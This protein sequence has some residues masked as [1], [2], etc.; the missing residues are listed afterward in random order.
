M[1]QPAKTY[2]PTGA[3][4]KPHLSTEISYGSRNLDA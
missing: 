3:D 1:T 4:G 2:P